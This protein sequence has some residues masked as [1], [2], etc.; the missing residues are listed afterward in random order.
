MIKSKNYDT[1][2]IYEGVFDET[3]HLEGM[4]TQNVEKALNDIDSLVRRI[5][6]NI[7]EDAVLLITSDHGKSDNGSHIDCKD[8][9]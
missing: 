1:L 5:V 2:F 3:A 9:N 4:H 8:K 6:N 7:D